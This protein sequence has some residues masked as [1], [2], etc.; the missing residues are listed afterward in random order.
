MHNCIMD[1]LESG[2]KNY[3]TLKSNSQCQNNIFG[4]ITYDRKVHVKSKAS[5]RKPRITV[6]YSTV[7]YIALDT[8]TYTVLR[9]FPCDIATE[10]PRGHNN[11]H[12]VIPLF[13]YPLER[14]QEL[15]FVAQL[16]LHRGQD[17]FLAQV[18][19]DL[20]GQPRDLVRY[21][22]CGSQPMASAWLSSRALCCASER[23]F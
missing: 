7:Q 15:R 10:S 16:H 12:H 4:S 3:V 22:F 2:N 23:C 1:W 5:N 19:T 13:S 6:Q 14:G 8:P 9:T 11:R 20:L 21:P 18:P 17:S